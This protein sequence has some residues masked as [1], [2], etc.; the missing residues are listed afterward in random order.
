MPFKEPD[1]PECSLLPA[2]Q[3]PLAVPPIRPNAFQPSVTT[4]NQCPGVFSESHL[5][6]AKTDQCPYGFLTPSPM[7]ARPLKLS[8]TPLSRAGFDCFL[9]RQW[10]ACK[11]HPS[12]LLPKNNSGVHS[13]HCGCQWPLEGTKAIIGWWRPLHIAT[14]QAYPTNR[15]SPSKSTSTSESCH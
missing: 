9:S 10:K 5:P 13:W 1:A 12:F 4:E 6:T 7:P 2:S 15:S 11:L 3:C 8:P 14:I